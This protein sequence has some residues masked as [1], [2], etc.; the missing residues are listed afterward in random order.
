MDEEKLR[1]QLALKLKRDDVPEPLWNDLKEDGYIADVS[2]T[3]EGFADLVR[4]AKRRIRFARAMEGRDTPPG[5][6]QVEVTP[7][8]NRHDIERALAV[9]TC[10]AKLAAMNPRVR[11][12]RDKILGG[13]LLTREQARAF[14]TSPATRFF[15][16]WQFQSWRIPI[17]H[18]A[19]IVADEW[20]DDGEAKYHNL[21]I[22]VDPP[23]DTKAV[24]RK[25]L[26]DYTLDYETLAY[27]GEGRYAG[28]VQLWPDSVLDA[29]RKLSDWLVE[30]YHWNQ[31][32][33]TGFVLTG[34]P[35]LVGPIRAHI[36]TSFGDHNHCAITLTI[37]A[38]V[39]ADS[40]LH[41]YRQ[42][43]REV[44]GRDN[45]HLATKNLA[46]LRFVFDRMDSRGQFPP[47]RKLRDLWNSEHSDWRYS[48]TRVFARD[49]RR[50]ER[51]VLYPNYRLLRS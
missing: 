1:K 35:P 4:V 22:F 17:D 45:R 2:L 41:T 15:R 6:S 16:R 26:S 25:V 21:T 51:S 18:N 42:I 40:V 14:V 13:K 23:G 31:A 32:Q 24:T 37:P 12:F 38:W 19:R 20:R 39:S 48:D 33:A 9:S 10:L 11:S 46:L 47:W 29:L 43:Q 3:G 7:K 49:F 34:E 30:Q 8:A 36:G 28:V 50:G 27:P 44:L 5:R